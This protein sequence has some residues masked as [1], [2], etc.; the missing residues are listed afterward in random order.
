MRLNVNKPVPPILQ[1]ETERTTV[2]KVAYCFWTKYPFSLSHEV[3]IPWP[4]IKS[5]QY[6]KSF[7]WPHLKGR[8]REPLGSF[9][10]ADI[11]CHSLENH[12]DVFISL[13]LKS[14]T[15]LRV[16]SGLSFQTAQMTY[17]LTCSLHRNH[18]ILSCGLWST[19]HTKTGSSLSAYEDIKDVP[20]AALPLSLICFPQ[21]VTNNCSW[22][23]SKIFLL[24]FILID[25]YNPIQSIQYNIW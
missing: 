18:W 15:V 3:P 1:K 16:F 9:W 25:E 4:Q 6:Q 23:A 7:E 22:S 12:T 21:S 17:E 11:R 19:G 10:K 2:L 5:N 24:D 14:L 8:T 13:V 20:S